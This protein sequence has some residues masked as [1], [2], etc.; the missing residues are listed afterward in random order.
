MDYEGYDVLRTETDFKEA[1][2]LTP[3]EIAKLTDELLIRL[4]KC[5]ESHPLDLPEDNPDNPYEN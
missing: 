2:R 1:I 5:Q 3:V 4:G